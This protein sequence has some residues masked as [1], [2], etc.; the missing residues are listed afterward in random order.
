MSAGS[1]DLMLIFARSAKAT[2]RLS[3]L[4]GAFL[5]GSRR[6][7]WRNPYGHTEVV[8]HTSFRCN[9]VDGKSPLV[10][11]CFGHLWQPLT[12]RRF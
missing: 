9:I 12:T 11:A 5:R 4:W 1:G 8:K 3:V 6:I 2:V 10:G 7:E